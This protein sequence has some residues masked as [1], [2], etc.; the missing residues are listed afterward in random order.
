MDPDAIDRTAVHE[1]LRAIRH[2]KPLDDSPLL[3]LSVLRARIRAMGRAD[4]PEGREAEL[5][6]YLD[7]VVAER[8]RDLRGTGTDAGSRALTPEQELG[9]LEAD[10]RAGS[11]DLEAWSMLYSHYLAASWVS[12]PKMAARLGVSSRT[13]TRRMDHG[14]ELLAQELRDREAVEAPAARHNIPHPMTRFIGRESEIG[15]VRR[16]LARHRMVTLTGVGGIGKSRLA[17]ELGRALAADY[18]DGVWMAELGAVEDEPQL[19]SSVATVFGLKEQPRREL[20]DV[21]CDFFETKHLL[22]ILDNCEHLT[23]GCAELVEAVLGRSADVQVLAT[24]RERLRVQGEYAWTVPGLS[25]PEPES[26]PSEPPRPTTLVHYDAV[27]LFTDRAMTAMPG[28]E[29]TADNAPHV[30]QVCTMLDGIPLATELAASR[31]KVLSPKELVERLATPL[32]LLKDGRRPT[33]PQHETL[34]STMDWSHALLDEK[35]QVLFRRLSVFRGGWTLDAAEA[36]CAGDGIEQSEVLDLLQRLVDKSLVNVLRQGG[37]RRY[38]MLRTVQ[39]YA[40]ERLEESQE[41]EPLRD[42]HLNHFLAWAEEAESELRG[43]NQV[44][45][46]DRLAEEHANMRGA[47]HCAHTAGDA[48]RGLRLSSAL[49]LFWMRRGHWLEGREVVREFLALESASE[50]SGPRTRAMYIAGVLAAVQDDHAVARSLG[51]EGLLISRR[52]GD[53]LGI[54]RCLGL[55]GQVAKAQGEPEVARALYEESLAIRRDLG[56]DSGVALV[57]MNLGKIAVSEADYPAA[58]K[59]CEQALAIRREQGDLAGIARSLGQLGIVA[60]CQGDSET[61]RA[62]IQEGLD[63]SRQVGDKVEVGHELVN[64]GTLQD[65][66]AVARTHQEEALK[67]FRHLGSKQDMAIALHNLASMVEEHDGPEAQALHEESLRIRRQIGDKWGIAYSLA[68]LADSARCRGDFDTAEGFLEESLA[69]RRELGFRRG[70]VH[71]IE[72]YSSLAAAQGRH[73]RAARLY[74]ASAARRQQIGAPL[75][76]EARAGMAESAATTRTALGDAAYDAAYAEGRTLTVDEAVAY[77]LG[78]VTWG[79]L[80]PVVAERLA[81]A[82][83]APQNEGA[84]PTPASGGSEPALVGGGAEPE[85]ASGAAHRAPDAPERSGAS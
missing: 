68:S 6:G 48:E 24:S 67:I 82:A 44:E 65:D 36:V 14:Y 22:L 37:A 7:Q 74:G 34:R 5:A 63:I 57:L 41:A 1:A 73:D 76:P 31:V 2:G 77:A 11:V 15:E 40:A 83:G 30:A 10:F 46:L 78:E 75:E 70:V 58:R 17:M 9:S 29:L 49:R 43:P 32:D 51:E 81:G 61:A 25:V 62:L 23:E 45:W 52:A 39:Q 64:L 19:A 60:A 50:H 71:C 33:R 55:L 16:V 85:L 84:V 4:S 12:L 38:A 72:A 3:R 42:R 69:I 8:L 20:I 53:K 27:R 56:D 47:L 28:F 18:A 66:L 21:L 26:E 79:K 80:A 59:L 54:A 35:D 13:L